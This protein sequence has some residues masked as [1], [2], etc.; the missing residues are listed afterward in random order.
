MDSYESDTM[1]CF[2]TKAWIDFNE[3]LL[4]AYCTFLD[5]KYW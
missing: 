4:I 2:Q 5:A 3:T 1:R